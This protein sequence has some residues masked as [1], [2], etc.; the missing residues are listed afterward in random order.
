MSWHWCFQ[1]ECTSKN[2]MVLVFSTGI[3]LE[4]G[5]DDVLSTGMHLKANSNYR[6]YQWE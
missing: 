3:Y 6:C 1:Q 4:Q 5:D 2:E